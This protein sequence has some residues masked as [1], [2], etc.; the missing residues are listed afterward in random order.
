MFLVRAE[1]RV[2]KLRKSPYVPDHPVLRLLFK[3]AFIIVVLSIAAA[4]LTFV[5]FARKA[6]HYRAIHGMI[7]A[8]T[9]KEV[10]F[11]YRYE[12]TFSVDRY[13]VLEELGAFISGAEMKSKFKPHKSHCA[14]TVSLKNDEVL[15][16][17]IFLYAKSKQTVIT[18]EDAGSYSAGYFV[19][20]D[21]KFFQ[22]LTE[23]TRFGTDAQT[24]Q[25]CSDINEANGPNHWLEPTP[26][27]RAAFSDA[28]FAVAAQPGR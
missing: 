24:L 7:N 25:F 10:T 3:V 9:I 1:K 26:R 2:E 4:A 22:W 20:G 5:N 18:I 8:T 19:S 6:P 23:S 12:P 28:A 21:K 16:Y 11:T 15:H 27:Y 14:M 17:N 13:K